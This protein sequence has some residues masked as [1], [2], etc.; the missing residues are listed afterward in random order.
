MTLR[1]DLRSIAVKEVGSHA[2]VGYVVEPPATTFEFDIAVADAQPDNL[3][4]ENHGGPVDY[5]DYVNPVDI[6]ESAIK[7]YDPDDTE[8]NTVLRSW[9][10]E[11]LSVGAR[12]PRTR[13]V[14]GLATKRYS[15]AI[16]KSNTADSGGVLLYAGDLP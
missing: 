15:M 4:Y 16:H 14:R 7:I 1:V 8:A 12:K 5:Y 6:G 10:L 13:R 2:L 11:N 9:K 3:M